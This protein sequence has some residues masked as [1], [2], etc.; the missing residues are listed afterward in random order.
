LATTDANAKLG[1]ARVGAAE[2]RTVCRNTIGVPTMSVEI[3]LKIPCKATIG[4]GETAAN[5]V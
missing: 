4:A 1:L 2:L 5:P 3:T